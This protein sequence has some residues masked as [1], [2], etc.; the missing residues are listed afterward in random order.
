MKNKVC[1]FNIIYLS[2]LKS[3]I[4]LY[5]VNIGLVYVWFLWGGVRGQVVSGVYI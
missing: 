1:L 5:Y 4:T 2:D 3:L